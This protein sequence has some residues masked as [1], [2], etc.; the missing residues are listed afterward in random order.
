MGM[1]ALEPGM[2]LRLART[3]ARVGRVV[4]W[5]ALLLLP[6]T[7]P[8]ALA[9]LIPNGLCMV[10]MVPGAAVGGLRWCVSLQSGNFAQSGSAHPWTS[11][12]KLSDN[13][14]AVG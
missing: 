14:L 5:W 7:S 10:G 2:G 4:G 1:A 6:S 3:L 11:S 13:H 9:P 12:N 8:I